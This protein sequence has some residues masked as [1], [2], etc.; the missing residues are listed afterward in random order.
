LN[1]Q[2]EVTFD[3]L[4]DEV[5]AHATVMEIDPAETLIEG[6]VY[7]EVTL[8]MNGD[9]ASL[10]LK[11]GMSADLDIRTAEESSVIAIPQRAVLTKTD[12]QKYVR[13]VTG[14]GTYEDR[15]VVTGVLGDKGMVLIVSG[16]SEGEE[17]ILKLNSL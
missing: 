2:V 8:Y 10:P 15:Q 13:V 9:A 1:D 11:P 16:L 7:Y 12:G 4:N 17:I 5:S 6:V 3:A 14:K